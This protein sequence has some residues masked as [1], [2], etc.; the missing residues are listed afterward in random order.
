MDIARG[1]HC[2]HSNGTSPI[3]HRDLKVLKPRLL[4]CLLISFSYLRKK[5]KKQKKSPNVLLVSFLPTDP[6]MAKVTDFGLAGVR[7]T[8]STKAVANPS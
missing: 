5:K 6:V 1:M 7:A 4:Y 8:V 2:L 3:I